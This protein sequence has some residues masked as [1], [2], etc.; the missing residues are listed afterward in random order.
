MLARQKGKGSE[1][2]KILSSNKTL[3]QKIK[4]EEKVKRPERNK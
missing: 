1:F 2:E 3:S 4:A